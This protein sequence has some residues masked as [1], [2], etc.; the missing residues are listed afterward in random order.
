MKEY[1]GVITGKKFTKG[2]EFDK[3]VFDLNETKERI[4]AKNSELRARLGVSN[5]S[6]EELHS[7]T[8][9]ILDSIGRKSI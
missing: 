1:V 4:K 3:L 7:K 5:M 9:D 6:G 8:K 2:E